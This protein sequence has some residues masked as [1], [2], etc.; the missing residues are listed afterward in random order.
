M[1]I[2]RQKTGF[3]LIELVVVIAILGI[4][5]GIAIPRLMDATAAARGAKI[6]ADLRTID[7]AVLVYNAKTG[8]MPSKDYIQELTTVA[9]PSEVKPTT[10]KLLAAWPIPPLGK[11]TIV[12]NYGHTMNVTSTKTKYTLD[13]T[14]DSPNYGRALY[15]YSSID[16]LMAFD[17]KSD[18]V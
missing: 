2:Q 3:T 7:S 6:V 16:N 4:L 11:V 18:R 1:K 13:L 17:D 15:N 10:Y 14:E 8:K 9:A 5:A 12:N